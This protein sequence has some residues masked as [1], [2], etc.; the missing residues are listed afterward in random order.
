MYEAFYGLT[1]D[2][3]RLLP[4]P[5]VCFPHKSC[6]KVWAY[7][8]YAVRRGEGIVVITG[9]PG[10]GKTTLGERLMEELERSRT[11]GVRLVAGGLNADALL[12]R[13]ASALGIASDS[14][15][16]AT[17]AYRV[18]CRLNELDRKEGRRVALLIDE[19]QT[20][21]PQT[22]EALRVLTDLQSPRSR[23]LLQLFLLGQEELEQV[24]QEP[25][26]EPFRQRIIASCRLC[27]MDLEETRSYLEYRLQRVGWRGDPAIDGRAVHAI[28][29][30]SRGLPRH[31]NRIAS[32]L[33]LYGSAEAKHELGEAEVLEVVRDLHDELL[34]ASGDETDL[35]PA[36]SPGP[37]ATFE[38]L[39]LHPP[40]DAPPETPPA[41][42]AEALRLPD[43]SPTP[44]PPSDTETARPRR[45][46]YRGHH[47]ARSHHLARRLKKR[48]TT[49]L[50]RGAR[51]I[52]TRT[53][54]LWSL[55]R[56]AAKRFKEWLIRRIR[57]AGS[58]CM[59]GANRQGSA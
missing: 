18:E 37:F 40:A 17:L 25:L 16:P 2:P 38:E 34:V 15:E 6:A 30:L 45:A 22:L 11:L 13:L 4:D 3:F 9:E 24:L 36:A 14:P 7:L 28:H 58:G 54:R 57:L 1:D 50:K 41:T 53:A 48:T 51:E 52:M 27:T 23:P 19:A 35:Q 44:P 46:A 43:P 12:F 29:R 21:S 49:W 59:D 26:L 47:H 10:T 31:V 5:G 55:A 33:L 56:T 32:R 20:L 8:R 42:P 39:A